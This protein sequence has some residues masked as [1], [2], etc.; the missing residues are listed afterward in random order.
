LYERHRWLFGP[1]GRLDDR[2]GGWPLL[3]NIGDHL[4]I[5]MTKR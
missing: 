2:L 1:L 3:R 4:L 5:V